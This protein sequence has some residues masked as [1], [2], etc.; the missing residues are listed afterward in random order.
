MLQ[1]PEVPFSSRVKFLKIQLLLLTGGSE[2]GMP[3]G[4]PPPPREHAFRPLLVCIATLQCIGCIGT[5]L[6]SLTPDRYPPNIAQPLTH[7]C[8]RPLS[9]SGRIQTNPY[10]SIR[11]MHQRQWILKNLSLPE[12]PW[13]TASNYNSRIAIS[14][15]L[16]CLMGQYGK[17]W[18]GCRSVAN[19]L[20]V[21][22]EPSWCFED[23]HVKRCLTNISRE[24]YVKSNLIE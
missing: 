2:A 13:Q 5:T 6:I 12:A 8:L 23:I 18:T 24:I 1:I 15:L 22:Q 14:L 11:D 21:V 4:N 20:L 9:N 17:Y 3:G 10:I 19:V 7:H 16:P